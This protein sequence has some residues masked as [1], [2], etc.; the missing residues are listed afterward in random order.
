MSGQRIKKRQPLSKEQDTSALPSDGKKASKRIWI[1]V[2]KILAGCFW[3]AIIT[4]CIINRNRI[5]VDAVLHY[6][7]SNPFLAAMVMLLLF[8]LKSLSIVVYCGILYTADGILFSLPSAI[9]LNILGTA[10]MISLPY[11][12]G[13]K[14]GKKAADSIL[15][16]FPKASWIRDFQ[17]KNDFALVLIARLIG[18]LPCD[19]ISLYCGACGIPYGK[20]LTAGMIGMLPLIIMLPI[21]G[22]SASHI[23]SPQ[24]IISAAVSLLCALGSFIAGAVITY[25]YKKQRKM[26]MTANISVNPDPINILATLDQNYIPYFNVMLSSLLYSNPDERFHVYLLHSS[27]C[28]EDMASTEEVLHSRGKLYLIKIQEQELNNAPTTDR[29]PKEIYYRIFAAKYLPEKLDRILYLDPDLI[30][31][32]S[33]R[34]LYDMPMGTALFAAASH[35]GNLLHFF[36]E[37]R[38]DIDETMPYINSGVML[39]NL[40][41]LRKEQS[42]QEVFDYI[43]SH[44]GKLILPDQDIISGLYGNRIIPLDSYCYNMTERLFLFHRQSGDKMDVDYVRRHS[45]II[46]YCGRN[47]PWKR[48]YV[49]KLDV[50]YQEACER[51]NITADKSEPTANIHGND[52]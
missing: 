27:L 9:L 31:N 30:V 26:S 7:P 43:N 40:R 44:R 24:F 51:M 52:S 11:V 20:Y 29:Y 47:K 28:E 10:V 48:G 35:I 36:N 19:M 6:T 4:I 22:N 3:L 49:G 34:E 42:Y 8:A 17:K 39:L 23:R 50:F 1:T 16:R 18:F 2:G 21:L 45:V 37:I 14:S 13:R 15:I 12:I 5:S 25:K 41:Q 33:V 38:L 32:K 46:H